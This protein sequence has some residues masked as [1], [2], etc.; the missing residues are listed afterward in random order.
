[1]IL[2]QT[3]IALC[4]NGC[5]HSPLSLPLSITS[6]RRPRAA[7][8]GG[9]TPS[10]QTS[11]EQVSRPAWTCCR[12]Y[13]SVRRDSTSTASADGKRRRRESQ[14][15]PWPAAQEP[16]PYD[17][18][19]ISKGSPYDKARFFELVKL[20]HPDRNHHTHHD[21]IPHPMKLERYRLVVAANTIL[22]DPA[23]RRLYDVY[24]AGWG[25]KSDME[26]NHREADRAWR[27]KP[28]N[29]SMNATWEDW[30]RWY[31]Q[32]DG[33]KQEPVF[34]SNGGFVGVIALL[35]LIGGWGQATRA[36]KHS[37]HLVDMRDEK[38]QVI[39]HEMQQRLAENT[40]KSREARVEKFLR[41]REGWGYDSSSSHGR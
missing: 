40:G 10:T 2:K 3:S 24:G 1:M 31:E 34:M 36:G 20:Y 18:F 13:A 14:A 12:G 39:S 22:S 35:V 17:I 27:Q 38:D 9:Q 15:L 41:Q 29:A 7:S 32:R 8:R 26:S 37:M 6:S 28:G 4:S 19:H 11:S 33:K 16:T 23:K 21:G 25:G 30:E 5:H